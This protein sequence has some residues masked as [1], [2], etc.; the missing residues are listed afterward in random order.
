MCRSVTPA[1]RGAVQVRVSVIQHRNTNSLNGYCRAADQNH[2]TSA[3]YDATRT[4]I[5][6]A[7][8]AFG[9]KNAAESARK[10][11]PGIV[12][13]RDFEEPGRVSDPPSRFERLKS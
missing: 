10:K 3:T 2:G 5:S 9:M 8:R 4:W 7:L 1:A 13:M 12:S 11:E 6:L